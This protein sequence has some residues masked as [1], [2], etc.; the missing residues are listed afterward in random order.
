MR[1]PRC[2]LVSSTA[3]GCYHCVS[4]CVRRAFLCGNDELTGRSFAHRKQWIEDRL[5][6]LANVFAA[7]VYAYAVMSNHVH[8]VIRIDPD[9]AAAW[10]AD[11]VAER[12]LRLFPVRSNDCID[13]DA[14]RMR[15][16]LIAAN[17]GL[18]ST[19]RERLSSLSWFM[20]CLNEPIARMANREDACTG[21]FWE[22]RY[23]CQALLDETAVLACMSYVDLNPV[24]AGAAI[25]LPS[26]QHTSVRKRLIRGVEAQV[27]LQPIAGTVCAELSLH[28]ADYVALV[29]WTGRRLYPGKRGR[30]LAPTPA[31]ILSRNIETDDWLSRV[32]S[33]ET[34]YWR[35]VGSIEALIDKAREIG[36]RWLKGVGTFRRTG[37]SATA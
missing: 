24:R 19:Y 28:D 4:R 26:S 13:G 18:V 27:L 14:C 11:E 20:R 35:A 10:T 32:S 17:P 2:Q 9:V 23:K 7:G 21:R 5:I 12:W 33:I 6:E 16:T 25:D 3:A 34:R 30:I 15:A 36:Q 29:E 22:G 31:C 8:V 1:T 37:R